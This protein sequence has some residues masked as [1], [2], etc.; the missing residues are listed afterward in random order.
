ML[1]AANGAEMNKNLALDGVDLEFSLA[2]HEKTGKY[3]HGRDLIQSNSD[4]IRRQL[5]WRV[6]L[7][8]V[9]RDLAARI[10][11]RLLV[12]E[13]NARVRSPLLDRLAPRQ[14]RR[15]SV[16]HMDPF[17]TLLHKLSARDIVLCHDVG[18]LTH[19]SLFEASVIDAYRLAYR[20]IARAR[21]HMVFVS[22]A[23]QRQFH[24]LF[25]GEFASSRVIYPPLRMELASGRQTPPPG[26]AKPFLLTVGSIGARKNQYRAIE[27]FARSGLAAHG[28]QY[29][30]CGAREPG[31]EAVLEL[32]ARTPG[33]LLL[34]FVSDEE[35]NW[36]YANSVG[37]VLPSLL[38]G[39]GVPVAE[40]A[41]HGLTPLVSAD[42]VLQEVAGDG[43]LLVDPMDVDQIAAGMQALHAMTPAEASRRRHALTA[44]LHRFSHDSFASA[45][46]SAILEAIGQPRPASQTGEPAVEDGWF[47]A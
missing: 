16:A 28:V 41:A 24:A 11:G 37:F 27:A 39:F 2:L 17:T 10:I 20:E 4:L 35:L 33:V 47:R 23:S 25:D 21:P 40:A 46:R 6:P 13:V 15:R 43:A 36:L 45:W 32:A 29:V 1:K 34:G 3:Y 22:R 12:I 5:F 18:P 8:F 42:S 14:R 7:G 9:P 38:E 44:S 26:V 31:H 30:L 19:P